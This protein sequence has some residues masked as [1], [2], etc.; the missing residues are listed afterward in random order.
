MKY[1][2]TIKSRPYLYKETK[3]AVTLIMQGLAVEDIKNKS[4]EENIFQFESEASMR[5]INGSYTF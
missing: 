1:K 5:S 3:K 4:L 2:S